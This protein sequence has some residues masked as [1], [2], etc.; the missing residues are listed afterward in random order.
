MGVRMALGAQQ[1]DVLRLVLRQG[2]LLAVVGVGLGI[3]LAALV[4]RVF[5]A[6]LYGVS[7]L[8]PLAY[9]VAATVLFVVAAAA[10]L[11][12]ALTAARVEPMRALRNE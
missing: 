11:V 3:L 5:S 9:G 4:G 8:D 6:L 1:A 2:S 12:P 10:N 7:S